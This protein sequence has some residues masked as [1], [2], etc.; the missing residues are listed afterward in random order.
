M[1]KKN[2]IIVIDFG[3]CMHRAI[4]AYINNKAVPCTFTFMKMLIGYLRKIGVDLDTTVIAAQDFGSWRKEIDKNYKAQRKDYRESKETAEFWKNIYKEFNEFII[5]LENCL[6]WQFVKIYKYEADD[7][8]S[9]ACRY[10]K[11]NEVILISADKDWEML[12]HFNNVKIFSP[13]TKKYKIVK[14]P[15]KV[16]LEKIQGD[17]SDNL[18]EKPKNEKEFQIRKKI[19]DLIKLP[20]EIEMTIREVF[21]NF[22]MKNMLIN[23]V[24]FYSIQKSLKDLYKID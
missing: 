12:C 5:K 16:L 10:Y 8:A 24:P 3:Y 4:F 7:I 15:A 22:P 17:I 13:I 11:E 14:N 2:K 23:K 20:S 9:V 1:D 18:L 21:D 6:N 19:V